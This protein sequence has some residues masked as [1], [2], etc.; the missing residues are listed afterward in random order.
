MGYH[1]DDYD[2]YDR[3]IRMREQKEKKKEK[4]KRETVRY[5]ELS[6][7][8]VKSQ[9]GELLNKI[10]T[11]IPK[12]FNKAVGK[13][14][15]VYFNQGQQKLRISLSV[16]P[17]AVVNFVVEAFRVKG[18]IADHSYSDDDKLYDYLLLGLP[19]DW[20]KRVL[21]IGRYRPIVEQIEDQKQKP[22]EEPQATKE[23]EAV[24]TNQ[25]YKFSLKEE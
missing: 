1:D 4:M 8:E 25:P 14:D 2:D 10:L 18:W 17:I 16:R 5:Q 12:H 9:G 20:L 11:A 24:A 7:D 21:G 22:A 13:K 6:H 23:E 19:Q 3:R 15:G